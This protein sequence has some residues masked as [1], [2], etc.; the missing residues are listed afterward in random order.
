MADLQI[1]G[2]LIDAGSNW[3]S[4]DKNIQYRQVFFSSTRTGN[5]VNACFEVKSPQNASLDDDERACINCLYSQSMDESYFIGN[6]ARAAV[7]R[8]LGVHLTEKERKLLHNKMDK[9]GSRNPLKCKGDLD[10]VLCLITNND[11][12]KTRNLTKGVR[13]YRWEVLENF[14]KDMARHVVSKPLSPL[15]TTIV[16]KLT[17]DVFHSPWILYQTTRNCPWKPIT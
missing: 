3:T 14:L 15:S 12:L 11:R 16:H 13:L 8:I 4:H 2:N 6:N 10:D 17:V 1:W 9:H 5:T 7:E